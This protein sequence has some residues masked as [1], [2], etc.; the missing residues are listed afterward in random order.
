[1]K[2]LLAALILLLA[3]A[4]HAITYQSVRAST[5]NV[6]TPSIQTGTMNLSSGT[7]TNL[8][9]TTLK[10][11]T[12]TFTGTVT[13]G[14]FSPASALSALL[15]ST[16]TWTA[17]Q[18][19]ARQVTLSSNVVDGSSSQGT[20]GQ[21]L[22]SNAGSAPTWVNV[23]SAI[24]STT[25]TWSAAQNLSTA[26]ITTLAV[27]SITVN[28]HVIAGGSAGTS[29]QVL[30]SQGTSPIAWNWK[31]LVQSVQCTVTSDSA[32]TS[33]TFVPTNLS[34]SITPKSASNKVKVTTL[35]TM[36]FSNAGNFIQTTINR[37][38]TNLAGS[39]PLAV[40]VD[41]VGTARPMASLTMTYLDS[42][43]TASA[44]TYTVY[45]LSGIAGQ[46]VTYGNTDTRVMI[47]DEIAP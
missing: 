9:T 16:N 11:A 5:A 7:I 47:L 6:V 43:L 17:G 12:G 41:S 24:L 33:A 10:G 21:S 2:K 40:L 34:C 25:S 20:A 29:G 22:Q 15:A 39:G 38:L 45:M 14:S 31:G 4:A 42:P 1:M 23:P 19:F 27:S 26:T 35:G 32:T 44:T 46:T 37:G 8:N 36:R 28:T 13:A 30:T 3:P 18:T